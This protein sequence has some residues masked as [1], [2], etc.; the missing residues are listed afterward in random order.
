MG[1]VVDGRAQ[2]SI[3]VTNFRLTPMKLVHAEV[4]RLARFQAVETAEGELIGLIPEAAYEPNAEWLRQIP[5][6]DPALKV[7]ERRLDGPIAWPEPF[8]KAS[9]QV[10]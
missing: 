3:N 8:H 6:F 9:L 10:A 7:L 2:V 5:Q 1:V 4:T